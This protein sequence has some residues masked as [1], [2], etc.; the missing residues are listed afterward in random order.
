M[1]LEVTREMSLGH[2]RIQVQPDMYPEDDYQVHL[3]FLSNSS[4]GEDYEI[5]LGPEDWQLFKD[6]ID[7]TFRHMQTYLCFL[8]A[9]LPRNCKQNSPGTGWGI[10]LAPHE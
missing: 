8:Q 3:N 6:L 1:P 4:S 7:E 10:L 9:L 5:Q 2:T